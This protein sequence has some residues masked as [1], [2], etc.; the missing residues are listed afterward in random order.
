MSQKID[1]F[2]E[3][4]ATGINAGLQVEI[5]RALTFGISSMNLNSPTIGSLKTKI[6]R[7]T[8]TG[9]AY[10]LETGSVLTVNALTDPDRSGRLLAAGDFQVNRTLRLMVGAAT[11]PS[12]ISAA[13][14]STSAQPVR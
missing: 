7:T 13:A 5:T 1:G 4:S 8:L 9:L 6:P 11:N 10:R 12:L 3:N 2:G 14:T